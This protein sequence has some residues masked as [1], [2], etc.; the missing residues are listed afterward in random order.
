MK[1]LPLDFYLYSSECVQELLQK[2]TRSPSSPRFLYR[3]CLEITAVS[4]YF[5]G[6]VIVLRAI[7]ETSVE[8]GWEHTGDDSLRVLRRSL[9]TLLLPAYQKVVQEKDT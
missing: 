5:L 6:S 7:E 9:G 4:P 1:L 8:V 3:R 2:G